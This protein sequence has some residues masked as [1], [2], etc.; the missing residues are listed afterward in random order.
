VWTLD[1]Y[2]GLALGEGVETWTEA[3]L[4]TVIV[5]GQP[6][7]TAVSPRGGVRWSATRD[8]ELHAELGRLYQVP[9][10]A[11]LV[12]IAEGRYQPLEQSDQLG[13]GFR[14]GASTL[15]LQ[16]DGW[17]RRT[18]GL[19]ELELDGSLGETFGRAS[20]VETQLH[21]Q[22]AGFDAT[23]LYEYTRSQKREDLDEVWGPSPFEVPH[24]VELLAIQALPRAWTLSG[25]FRF[26]SG[27]PRLSD[28][29]VLQPTEAY[30]LLLQRTVQLALAPDDET[31]APYHSLDLRIGRTFSFRTWQLE[32]S[33]DV[34]NVYSRRVVEP[35][36]TG[37]GESRPSYGFGLPILPI[38]ALDGKF[39]PGR[40]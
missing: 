8:L 7:R 34:Q 38:F 39:W 2:A 21:G 23:A 29:A 22:V 11:L 12:G 9:P 6:L 18:S 17:L 1:P 40:P 19:S 31:L 24:R 10:P 20:G 16:A 28:G 25:R 3:R 14:V 30:D 33:L 36:I 13:T 15:S 27:Y 37:F 26:T 4:H 35:V 5:P 32:A